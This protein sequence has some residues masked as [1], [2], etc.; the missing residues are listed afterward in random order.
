ML[1]HVGSDNLLSFWCTY[2]CFLIKFL[3]VI[4]IML[5]LCLMLSIMLDALNIYYVLNY[6]IVIRA[7]CGVYEIYKPEGLGCSARAKRGRY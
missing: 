4:P 7:Q 6:I 3:N 5:A 1:M 2:L